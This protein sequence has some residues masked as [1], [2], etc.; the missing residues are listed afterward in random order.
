MTIH[1]AADPWHS[2]LAPPYAQGK[3]TVD[4]TF[5]PLCYPP[6]PLVLLGGGGGGGGGLIPL[7]YPWGAP[8]SVCQPDSVAL[9]GM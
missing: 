4:V 8:C 9:L 3:K 7:L 6:L 5:R 2:L 1:R